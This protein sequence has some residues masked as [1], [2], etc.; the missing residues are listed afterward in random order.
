MKICAISDIHGKLINIPECDILCI[1]GDIIP[2]EIQQDFDKSKHWFLN[3]FAEWINNFTCKKVIIIPGNHDLYLEECYDEDKVISFKEELKNATFGKLELLIDELYEY[4]GIKF[5]GTP[6]IKQIG[7]AKRWAFEISNLEYDKS[8]DLYKNIPE[9]DI[10]LT[11]DNPNYNDEL[12]SYCHDKYKH[13]FFG[14]W[15]EGRSYGHLNQHNCSILNNYY[16][17][18]GNLKIVTIEIE[19]K[20]KDDED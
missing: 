10:L 8:F 2:L 6:W 9:C 12:W 15:H 18:Y 19:T 1:T 17:V 7:F 5:Y 20:K 14:H 13:H 16:R 3:D 11:H 4:H